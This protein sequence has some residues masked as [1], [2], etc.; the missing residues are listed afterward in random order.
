MFARKLAVALMMS[1]I[2]LLTTSLA[3]SQEEINLNFTQ[4]IPPDSP[5]A[6]VFVAAAEEYMAQ[7]PNITI[8][9]N[10]I[11]FGD[12]ITTLPLRLSGSNPPD[13][14]WL[15]ESSAPTW[16]ESGI[17]ADM[18]PALRS[19]ENYNFDDLTP[20]AMGLWV[21]DEAVYGVPFSTS[22]LILIYNASIFA[23]AS[24][25]NP[26]EML[27]AG[28]YTWENLAENLRLVKEATGSDGFQSING[29]MYSGER[30]WQTL[31]PI[32]R[33]YGGDAW[34]EDN[35]C[36]M[37]TPETVEAIELVHRMIFEDETFEQPGQSIDFYSGGV[38]IL[39]GQLSRV[40]PLAEA[41][42]DWDI[43]PMPTGPAGQANVIGQAAFVIFRNSPN[44][45]VAVDFLSYLTNAENALAMAEFFPPIRQS[46][47]ETDVLLESNPTIDPASMLAAVIEPLA[48]ARVNPVHS[49][50][51]TIDLTS[52]PIFDS[53]WNPDADVQS[54]MDEMCN[55]IQPLLNQ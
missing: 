42:F 17:L 53:L 54:V 32:I 29:A 19:D 8:E 33:S 38:A 1:V 50:Y 26:N 39:M 31:T 10:F 16:V 37:S 11:P 52:R 18:G 13:G 48:D 20:G 36:L 46:V 34:N 23:E 6:S 22:P 14:G 7:N 12:Y 21:D 24:V 30:V 43:A 40:A 25:P 35:A 47:L 9:F 27:E 44:Q 2:L 51:P 45:D 41:D 55:S 4:W 15:L 3:S 28:D 49:N 5:R